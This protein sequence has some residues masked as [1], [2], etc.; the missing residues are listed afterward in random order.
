M[1]YTVSANIYSEQLGSYIEHYEGGAFGTLEEA[2][3]FWC[4]W[5]PPVEDVRAKCLTDHL[6][7]SRSAGDRYEVEV[8][9][10]DE[11]GNLCGYGDDSFTDEYFFNQAIDGWRYGK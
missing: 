5:M 4:R 6:W 7:H 10:W 1:T 9:I 8:A 11:R 2:A 3:D